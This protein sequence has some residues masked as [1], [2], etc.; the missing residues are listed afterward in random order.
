MSA[1]SSAPVS[2]RR[3]A[4]QLR[5]VTRIWP[6]GV[7]ALSEIDLTLPAASVVGLVGPN[8]GGKS[9]LLAL[10][11]G[12]LAPTTGS[13]RVLGHDPSRRRDRRELRRRIG[14]LNQDIALDNEMTGAETLSL[15]AVLHGVPR[16]QSRIR[17]DELSEQWGLGDYV[18]RQVGTYS[19]GLKRRLHLALGG[20]VAFDVLLLDEPTTGLDAAGREVV[21]RWVDAHR[22]GGGTA[23][24]STH[25]L[26]AAGTQCDAVIVVVGGRIVALGPPAQLLETHGAAD[27]AEVYTVLTGSPPD[28]PAPPKE[29]RRRR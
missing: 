29:R 17:C 14:Y 18:D 19:G 1:P 21:W 12:R 7:T 15:F 16:R 4:A 9:T 2:S 22:G 23:V 20:V 3:P 24:I 28:A 11:A 5:G 26:A 8:G 13:I 10:L 25:D 6:G 27:L